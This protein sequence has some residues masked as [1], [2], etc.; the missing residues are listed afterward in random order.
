M[1]MAMIGTVLVVSFG[2]YLILDVF[3]DLQ[4]GV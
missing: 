1:K 2:I 3:T 4:S